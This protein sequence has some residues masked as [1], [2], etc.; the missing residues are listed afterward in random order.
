[1]LDV[2]RLRPWDDAIAVT[3][4]QVREVFQRLYGAGQWRIGDPPV[5]VVLDAGYDVTRL[6]FL[7]ADLPVEVSP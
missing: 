5:V 2:L 7:L 6:A 3:A 4:N 1:M